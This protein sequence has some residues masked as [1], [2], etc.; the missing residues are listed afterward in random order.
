MGAVSSHNQ[1]LSIPASLS[2]AEQAALVDQAVQRI[3]SIAGDMILRAYEIGR[4]VWEEILHEGRAP[5]GHNLVQRIAEHPQLEISRSSLFNCISLAR[6]YPELGTGRVPDRLKGL[7]LSHLYVLSRVALPEDR[8]WF[9]HRAIK[10]R[11]SVRKLDAYAASHNYQRPAND[12]DPA[13]LDPDEPKA[14]SAPVR[15]KEGVYPISSML[16]T[17]RAVGP[18]SFR[19]LPSRTQLRGWDR[20]LFDCGLGTVR[21]EDLCL[22]R[23]FVEIA[24]ARGQ[25]SVEIASDGDTIVVSAEGISLRIERARLSG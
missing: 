14:V 23:A 18:A 16:E 25:G 20:L 9:E 1:Q 4:Y 7:T 10:K 6:A 24:D 8:R 17:L 5:Y 3:N 21:A 11:W 13:S 2:P 19:V 22:L 12:D 15:L